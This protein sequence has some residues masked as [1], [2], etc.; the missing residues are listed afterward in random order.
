MDFRSIVCRAGSYVFG[1]FLFVSLFPSQAHAA[2][3]TPDLLIVVDNSCSMAGTNWSAATTAVNTITTQYNGKLRLGLENFN[4]AATIL[5]GIPQ[6]VNAGNNCGA[7]L[8]AAMASIGP[9]GGT[10]LTAAITAADNHLSSV[11]ASDAVPARKRSVLFLTDGQATCAQTQVA[12]LNSKGI[13]TYVIGFGTGVDANCLNNMATSGGTALAGSRKY[14]QADN[15]NELN[16]AMTAIANAASTEICNGLDDDCDG[17]TDENITQ[18]CSGPCGAG[19][20]VC[21]NGNFGTCSTAQQPQPET[22]NNKDDDCDGKTDEMLTRNCSTACGTG[23]ETCG[24]GKWAGCTAPKPKT[25]TCDGTD[26]D[27]DGKVDEGVKRTCQSACG[28]GE[29]TCNNGKWENCSAQQPKAETCDGTDEDCD[30]KVDEMLT[31]NCSSACGPGTETCNNGKWENCNAPTPTPETCDGKDNDCDGQVDNDVTRP[32]QSKCGAGKETC[33]NGQWGACDAQQPQPEVCNNKDDDCDGQVDNY[34]PTTQC[35]ACV[36]GIC[37][38]K[39]SNECPRGFVCKDGLCRENPCTRIKCGNDQYCKD[40]QCVDA[41][42]NVQCNA[43]QVCV[44]GQCED[45][46]TKDCYQL[47]CPAGQSCQNGQCVADPCTGVTC[48]GTQYCKEG[49]CV[50]TCANVTCPKGASCKDGQCVT[51]TGCEA[52]TCADD[53]LCK[54]GKC[55]PPSQHPCAGVKCDEGRYCEEG[56]CVGDPCVNIVCPEGNVCKEGQCYG[57]TTP[58]PENPNWSEF[59]PEGGSPDGGAEPVTT[60]EPNQTAEPVVGPDEAKDTGE[61]LESS[62]SRERFQAVGCACDSQS[63]LQSAPLWFLAF[64]LFFFVARRRRA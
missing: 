57:G 38:K 44:K 59:T 1:L 46:G 10:N 50:D 54:D 19:V 60:T 14:Y 13:K 4:S 15:S 24:A 43:N 3:E 49:K 47:G 8:R 55:I 5:F 35:E 40:G 27:C 41:C 16:Q 63:P 7:Q 45:K 56:Q 52:V 64:A 6:C 36:L 53:E 25:E 9:T 22:C 58:P 42:A 30:G 32:C 37:Y 21:Q 61:I 26:E 29:E 12:T 34:T 17:N 31:Q 51:P 18:A 20:Q 33:S 11:K 28:A 2:C 23:I 39:C 48:Q 62:S